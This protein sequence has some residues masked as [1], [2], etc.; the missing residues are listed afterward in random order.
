[1]VKLAFYKGNGKTL[2]RLIRWWTKGQ[3]SHCELVFSDGMF[4]SADAWSN[5]VRY[6]KVYANPDNWDFVDVVMT[7]REE[8]AV[9]AWCDSQ[10]G[11]KYDYVG[12]LFAQILPLSIDMPSTWF[13]S[14]ICVAA[15]QRV[16]KLIGLRGQDISP[17]DLAKIY[18]VF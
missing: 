8:L 13:C 10:N 6:E 7:R 15:L 16:G 3:Y 18:E 1:M 12:I 14:E 4:F 17:V 9:R 11:K 2:D 5:K